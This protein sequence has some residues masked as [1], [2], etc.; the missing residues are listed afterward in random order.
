MVWRWVEH[1]RRIMRAVK[2]R[3]GRKEWSFDMPSGDGVAQFLVAGAH[4]AEL[5]EPMDQLRP[6]V[7]D[8]RQEKAATGSRAQC[9]CRDQRLLDRQI[10]ALKIDA[11]KTVNL[12]I[13]Q[14]GSQPKLAAWWSCCSLELIDDSLPPTHA[15]SLPCRVVPGP[16]FAVAHGSISVTSSTDCKRFAGR[17][18]L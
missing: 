4:L 5:R 13:D 14:R 8:Q 16:D 17:K 15:D 2:A 9:P 10:V 12:Q 7:G 3:F 11:G 6:F 18:T 1:Q